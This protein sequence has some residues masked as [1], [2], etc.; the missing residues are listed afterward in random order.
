MW[1][2]RPDEATTRLVGR[3]ERKVSQLVL[4]KPFWAGKWRQCYQAAQRGGR[5]GPLLF[6][7][8]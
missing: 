8:N 5:H 2:R 6:Q 7:S 3:M 4:H 1:S